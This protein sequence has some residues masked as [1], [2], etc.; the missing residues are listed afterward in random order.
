MTRVLRGAV[1]F[2]AVGL[3]LG[4]G[5]ASQRAAE[6]AGDVDAGVLAHNREIG[7]RY[8]NEVWN[9]GRVDVLDELLTDNYV[10][11][12]PSTPNPPRG[13]KG[14]KPIVQAIRQGFP[15]L[16]FQIE[17]MVVTKDRVVLRTV[18]TGTN[19]GE[20]FGAPPTGRRVRVN[21]INIEEIRDGRIADHWRVTDEL[22]IQK[23]L[24]AR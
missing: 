11:H 5:G 24:Q 9:Q 6:S 16:H 19:T 13:P 18:M 2:G 23:Q 4:C 22:S 8:F 3:G 20:L 17:D 1:L 15:D 7:T 14:L 21:Q 12:T 10:N